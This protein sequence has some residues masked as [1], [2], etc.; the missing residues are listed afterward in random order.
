[1]TETQT[2]IRITIT[3]AGVPYAQAVVAGRHVLAADEPVSKGGR[4]AV[5][6]RTG[7]MLVGLLCL[8]GTS[9]PVLGDMR[10]EFIAVAGYALV[11][12]FVF[13]L[14]AIRFLR[15]SQSAK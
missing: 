10:L 9:G 11:L 2:Q 1:M 4:F 5:V 8:A 15:H 12:P 7:L 6:V 13:F 14:L 3:E